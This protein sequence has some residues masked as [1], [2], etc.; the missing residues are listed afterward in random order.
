MNGHLSG[1]EIITCNIE[2]GRDDGLGHVEILTNGSFTRSWELNNCKL[3]IERGSVERID[4]LVSGGDVITRHL[5]G[6][7]EFRLRAKLTHLN[8]NKASA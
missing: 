7:I 4:R 5:T 1:E 3:F 2:F 8:L 6:E